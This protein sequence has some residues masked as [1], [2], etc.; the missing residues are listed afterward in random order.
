MSKRKGKAKTEIE[1]N[2]DVSFV[3][4]EIREAYRHVKNNKSI[5]FTCFRL[6]SPP[7]RPF[8]LN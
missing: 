3:N 7:P 8:I 1:G 5:I 6:T 4:P 2:S